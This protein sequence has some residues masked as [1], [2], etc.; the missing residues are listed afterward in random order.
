MV[1]SSI[2][3]IFIVI[4]IMINNITPESPMGVTACQALLEARYT[5]ELIHQIQATAL[6]R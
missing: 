4:I 3:L 1:E 5:C 2:K 6:Q